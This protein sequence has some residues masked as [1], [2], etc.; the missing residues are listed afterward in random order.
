VQHLLKGEHS[1]LLLS[2]NYQWTNIIIESLILPT[3]FAQRHPYN[4]EAVLFAQG[5][6]PSTKTPLQYR[7]RLDIGYMDEDHWIVMPRQTTP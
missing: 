7:L 4:A 2:S 1:D 3:N 5:L 6:H